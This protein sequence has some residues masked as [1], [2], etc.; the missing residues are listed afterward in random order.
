MRCR[1]LRTL[2]SV[3]YINVVNVTA[4]LGFWAIAMGASLYGEAIEEPRQPPPAKLFP[5]PVA[6]P[7]WTT[8]TAFTDMAT[9]L[10]LGG[11]TIVVQVSQ[12][13]AHSPI[14]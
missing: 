12:P 1:Q 9:G 8:Q 2:R 7:D 10:P 6:L 4:I 14:R 5:A 11:I 13:K 3:V